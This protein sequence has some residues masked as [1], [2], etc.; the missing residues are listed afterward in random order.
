MPPGID[1]ARQHGAS[2]EV[3]LRGVAHRGQGLGLRADERDPAVLDGYRVRIAGGIALHRQNG[4]IVIDR[5]R[6]RAAIG[7]TS[8]RLGEGRC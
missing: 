4:A 8:R 2:G 1:E 7:V 5:R 6:R 3:D